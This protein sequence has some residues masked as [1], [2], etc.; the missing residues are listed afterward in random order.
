MKSAVGVNA[1]LFNYAACIINLLNDNEVE[2]QIN[3]PMKPH[4]I[5]LINYSCRVF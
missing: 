2:E 4:C 3:I 1:E 5:I